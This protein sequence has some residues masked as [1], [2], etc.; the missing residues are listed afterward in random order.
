[1]RYLDAATNQAAQQGLSIE[2]V[3]ADMRVFQRPDSFDGAINLFTSFGYFDDESD[4][5]MVAR[6]LA[7]SQLRRSS[8]SYGS[9]R[10]RSRG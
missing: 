9:R 1:M 6:N 7:S 4:D 10:L 3:H 8:D 5:L 2:F